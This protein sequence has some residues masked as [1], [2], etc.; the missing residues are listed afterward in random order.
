MKLKKKVWNQVRD[1]VDWK[2]QIQVKNRV[3]DQVR[4]KVWNQVCRKVYWQV[5]ESS[6]ETSLTKYKRKRFINEY[7]KETL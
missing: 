6:S 4:D 3:Y 2:V 7:Q 1:Q 5:R